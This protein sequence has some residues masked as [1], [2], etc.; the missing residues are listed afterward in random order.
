MEPILHEWG[1]LLLRWA[2]VI[3]A[4][5]WIG[6]SLH[7]MHL[8]ASLRA[9]ADGQG[10]EAWEV[11]GGGFYQ[12]RK[13]LVAPGHLPDELTW[14]KW[15]S[16][17]T[18]LTGFFLLVWVYYYQSSLFLIDPAILALTPLAALGIGLGGLAAGWLAYDWLCKS[19]LGGNLV[20]LAVVGFVLIIAMA[21]FFQMV[22]SPRGAFIHTGALMA[23]IMSGN[24][25]FII[26]PNQKKVV[27]AL[28][29]GQAPDP[30]LGKA[31]KQRSA[32]NNYLTLPVVFLM[33][34][35]HSPLAYSSPYAFVVVGLI[36]VAGAL[37]RLFYNQRHAGAGNQWWCWALAIACIWTALWISMGSSPGG[38]DMLGL[39][40]AS[41][42][43]SPA[44]A[45]I[46]PL[47][48]DQVVE[49][50]N[51]RCAMCHASAPA[52]E[53]I[54]IA[55]KGVR[56][57]TPENIARHAPEI[58]IQSVITHAM[59]PNNITGLSLRE[60]GILAHWLAGR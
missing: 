17:A 21:A 47:P 37:I 30:A 3:T 28:M 20:A 4:M 53:G 27:A 42:A 46:G 34:S 11:H 33:L 55:P 19:A 44:I 6:S 15:Q 51:S 57:D 40:L 25:F 24:V 9:R 13:Y 16:Y 5:A 39:P 32:H 31:A 26:I 36:L 2:H 41:L 48:P 56:L 14:H 12:M 59:P 52:W 50:V 43:T 35:S 38:R 18:W 58:R 54:G 8:D 10:L 49:V 22:F 29:A 1:S 60:R 23:T 45:D 7:F